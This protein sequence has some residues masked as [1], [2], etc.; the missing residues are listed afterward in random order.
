[1]SCVSQKSTITGV[2][3][4][5]AM[6][7][8]DIYQ[9][10]LDIPEIANEPELNQLISEQVNNW[11]DDFVNDAELNR[12]AAEDFGSPF[13]FEN[14]WKLG[15]NTDDCTSVLLTAYQFTGGA[16]GEDK[17]ASIT[18]NKITNKPMTI[19]EFL[20]LVLVEPSLESLAQACRK[21]LT[22]ALA[23]ENNPDL[24]DMIDSGT[25]PTPANYNV[26]TISEQGL[27]IYF[28]KYQVA[29][30]SAGTQ[31]VLLPYLQ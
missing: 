17:M 1:M 9:A 25:E 29:P 12:Q 22:I 16:N 10:D 24:V 13:T 14:Q 3:S 31:A 26:F 11:F 28:E 2:S 6:P 21:E 19:E 4:I 7:S 8:T 5:R 15:L 30:G 20:P 18:W 23:A 27:T